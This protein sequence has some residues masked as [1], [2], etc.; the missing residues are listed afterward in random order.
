MSSASAAKDVPPAK[1]RLMRDFKKVQKD[2]P[3]GISAV[4]ADKGL[5]MWDAVM[6]GPDGTSWEGGTFK[7]KM[8]FNDDYP[9]KPPRV[10]FTTKMFHPNIYNDG[11]ICLDI[12]QSQWSPT[13]DVC[14]ILTSIQSLLTDPNPNS[15]AN[16]EAARMYRE[17][18]KDYDMKVRSVVEQSWEDDEDEDGGA[19]GDEEEEEDEEAEAE[20]EEGA[21]AEEGK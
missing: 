4:P 16:G 18:R 10:T 8:E 14:A 11:S 2:A 13:Y 9:N 15:P 21:A 20:A 17:S 5:M 3:S 12:L 6:F 1:R 19:E 7:L